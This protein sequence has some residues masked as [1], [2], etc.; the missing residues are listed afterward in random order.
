MKK[1][2]KQG[3][4][5]RA[6]S[7][8]EPSL[9]DFT[10][11]LVTFDKLSE[12]LK[13]FKSPPFQKLNDQQR[14]SKINQTLLQLIQKQKE[15]CFLL[16]AVLD[17]IAR[18]DALKVLEAYAF[19]HF[20]LWLNQFSLLSAEENLKVRAKITGKRVPRDEYQC[21][22]PIGMGKTYPGSHFVTAHG[23]PDLDT[24]IAS[25]WGWVDAFSARVSENL[26][27]WNIPGGPP[28]SQ[29]E[30][31]MLFQEIFGQTIFQHLIKTRTSLFLSSVEMMT[32][33]GLVYKKTD[34]SSLSVDHGSA[35]N[36]VVLV[37]DGGFYLGDW[38]SFDGEGV[39]H[40]IILLN[41]CLRWF[42]S[43]LHVKMI[44][45]FGR[46]NLSAKDFPPFVKSMF[47]LKIRE[48][49]PAK[50]FTE[51]QKLHLQDYLQ[52]VLR[53][54]SG[55][56]CT[57]EEFSQ[58]MKKL[59]VVEFHEFVKLVESIQKS[60]LFDKSGA[61]LDQ[62]SK[63]F[64][65]LEKVIKGLDLAILSVRNFVDRL[66]VAFNIKTQVFGHVSQS[67]SYR[68]DIE[69]MR[70][71]MGNFPYLTV[72]SSDKEG[73]L[74]P[75]GIVHASDLHKPILGTVTL[76]DFCNRDETRIPSYFEVISVIDHHKTSM[77][78]LSAPVCMISDSQSSNVLCAELAFSIND[79][80]SLGGM[81]L[82]QIEAQ[83]KQ[84]ESKLSSAAQ[85]RIFQRL[86]QRH[87]VAEHVQDFYV[88]P[89][90]EYVEYLQFLFGILDDTD[91]LTK[92]SLRDVV[93]VASLL[94][95]LKSLMLG[96]EVEV[97]SLDDLPRDETF[98]AKAAKRILQNPDMYSLY[99]KIYLTKEQSVVENFKKCALGSSSA[100]FVDTKE[101]NGCARVGQ[102]KM[103]SSNYPAF[104]KYGKK[105]QE[106]W[107][108]DGLAV[109]KAHA[110]IDL[111][112]HMI[113]TVAGAEDLFKGKD[114]DFSHQDELWIWIPFSEQSVEHLKAFLNAFKEAKP[115]INN[116]MKV[117][118]YGAK[119]KEYEKIFSES[120]TAI[121]K[122]LFVEKG[123]LSIA[124]LKY[125][126]G[127][128]NSRKAMIS[129]YLP[130]LS[131]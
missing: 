76:R 74:M 38:R 33:K 107:V 92:V 91:L 30:I 64:A 37:D 61:L 6:S 46:S 94:N 22:F 113:S 26:H 36:A 25:F 128:I 56:D 57:I 67:V 126:A 4:S 116:P 17:F 87:L 86:L 119:A 112:L 41:S 31:G 80:Y 45:L 62:R 104:V 50:E 40:V 58:G 13:E 109:W 51:T 106:K 110:E 114:D 93:C 70:G 47:C 71:K 10:I 24:T 42:A 95:R 131:G 100:V 83:M 14:R 102:T 115:L 88:D 96:K 79:R 1:G 54:K 8:S 122:E 27:F 52:K 48:C 15:P 78:T 85:K 43:H 68:A 120:F 34:V 77:Q 101:Q 108:E 105:I 99:R 63:I 118:L 72:T 97:V 130:R 127:S 20:E 3:G 73:R 9:G 32:Q 11:Q 18:V 39:R 117:E 5:A 53:I 28:M 84:V 103:F 44:S 125:K 16:A 19:S 69:E 7:A 75:L 60:S 81:S 66:D 98:V 90:R 21:L 121:P 111:H 59:D 2:K 55:I 129:P 123:S 35:Q 49:E 124:V 29:V 23:S 65:A 82:K 12:K 89:M